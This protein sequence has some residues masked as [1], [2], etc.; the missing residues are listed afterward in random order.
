MR[1]EKKI[2]LD[3]QYYSLVIFLSIHMLFEFPHKKSHLPLGFFHIAPTYSLTPCQS[4]QLS[5]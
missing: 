5:N 1:L 2:K 4:W 3:G